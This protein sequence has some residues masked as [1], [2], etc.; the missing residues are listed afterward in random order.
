L[1]IL[2]HRLSLDTAL[3]A[4][5]LA[6]LLGTTVF[7]PEL[8]AN[9]HGALA[10]GS[11]LLLIV[12]TGLARAGAGALPG[13]ILGMGRDTIEA[14]KI[15]TQQ[16]L[17]LV[18]VCACAGIV[19]GVIGLT[20]LGGRFSALLLGLAGQS[21]FLALIFAMFISLIL[22][23]GMPTTAAYAIAAS[24]VAPSLQRLGL[25]VLSVHLFI[26]YFAVISTIT[27]PIALSA[28]A[29]AALAGADPWRTSFKAVRYGIAAFVVPFLFIYNQGILL[30]G[31]IIEIIRTTISAA[32]GVWALASA[33]EGWMCGRMPAWQRVLLA[34]AALCLISGDLWTD[35]A[36]YVIGGGLVA[37]RYLGGS[38]SRPMDRQDQT[39]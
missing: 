36:G 8:S 2:L 1:V 31:S 20:G 14:L 13:A 16:S 38:R 33:S 19:V 11:G 37:L 30:D 21:E 6:V 23:M 7:L 22:G 26:F 39:T 17:Q 15:A 18:A 28:F 9:Q 35:I 3:L 32:L 24:V 34:V 5:P 25:P 12:G 29:G 27:P 10:I 4:L